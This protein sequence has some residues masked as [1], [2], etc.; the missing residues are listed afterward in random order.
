MRFLFFV[1]GDGRGHITQALALAPILQQRGHTVG[2]FVVGCAPETRLP[3]FLHAKATAPVETVYSPNFVPDSKHK[4]I[5]W[6]RTLMH[7][8]RNL[9]SY[10]ATFDTISRAIET[11]RPDVLVNMYDPALTLYTLRKRVIPPVVHIAHQYLMLHRVFV[12]PPDRALERQTVLSYTKFTRMRTSKMLALSFYEVE[13]DEENRIYPVPPLLRSEVYERESA[14]G[15]HFLVYVLNHGLADEVEEFNRRFPEIPIHAFWNKKE[16]PETWEASPTLTF[17]QLNDTLFLDKMASCRGVA[18]TAGFETVSEAFYYRKPA[19]LMPS[20]GQYE[21]FANAFDAERIGAG[22]MVSTLDL[23][24]L[25]EYLPHYH[26]KHDTYLRWLN[27]CSAKI[28]YHL[29]NPLADGC[30]FH[31]AN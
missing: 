26:P 27:Q 14:P 25:N 12:F 29:E 7:G 15:D 20:P 30:S 9:P 3:A 1:K 24:L 22:R 5:S 11:H 23:A 2:A 8:F 13:D 31:A 18:C 10:R 4:G 6:A 19:L 21:Q 28:L 17:H 16:A